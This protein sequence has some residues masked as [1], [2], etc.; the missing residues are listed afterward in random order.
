MKRLFLIPVLLLTLLGANPAFSADLQK[1]LDAYNKGN[2][3][4]ALK[5]LRPLAEQGVAGAQNNLG[6]IV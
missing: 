3:A 1:G 4:T 2:F 5:E 6:M